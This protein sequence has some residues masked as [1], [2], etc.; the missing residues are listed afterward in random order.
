MTEQSLAI[1]IDLGTT[2][3]AI[4]VWHEG[5]AELIPNAVGKGLTPSVISIDEERNIM[6]GDAAKSRLI[7]RPDQ[8]A[9][10]FKRFLGTDKK[11]RLGQAEYSP[12]ELCSMVLK[13]LK[14]DAE[15]FLGSDVIDVVISVPAYFND[16]Q[17][18]QVTLAAE[19][20][21]LNAV[22]LINEPTAACL[23]YSLHETHDRQFLVFDLGGGTFDVT[24]V[25]HQEG[26]IEVRASAGD[27]FL[28]GDDF[29]A[30]LCS[31]VCNK[32]E[33]DAQSM[34]LKLLAK[35]MMA[36]EQAKQSEG[37]EIK[38]ALSEP[39]NQ[40]LTIDQ[41]Q[42]SQIWQE[43]LS[44]LGKPLRQALYDARISPKEIDELIFVGGATRL[45]LVQKMATRLIGR[46]G[47]SSLDPDLV[48]AMGAATQ[49]ACR[50]RD[51]A[52]EEI[53]LTDVAPFSL[54]VASN[55]EGQS[56]VFTPIIER[57]TVVPTS[58]VERF[59]TTYDDQDGV[60]IEV[61]QGERLWVKE[62]IFIDR[63]EVDVPKNSAGEEALDVRFSYDINGLLEVDVTIVSSGDITQKLIDRSPKEMNEEEKQRSRQRL[64]KL[65]YHPRD[66]IP[67]ITLMEKLGRLYEEKLSHERY[68]IEQLI[69]HLNSALESQDESKIREAV[70]KI[71]LEVAA[72]E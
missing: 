15:A 22:R 16:Q 54:G 21:G 23:A 69:F 48:V 70:K 33:L 3:S 42:A 39:I 61:Y 67:N 34:D 35:I 11:Y 49:A 29:T 55:R 38:I 37:A 51:E 52:V 63:M 25:E 43:L 24:I 53:V 8:T 50:L 14:S 19:L 46:F 62:N 72:Y 7:T 9:G 57:N 1:G 36:C 6:V 18:K 17:R 40:T 65:K 4:A 28:G 47:K 68:H 45:G 31:W 60:I 5:K 26:F 20:A 64:A 10:G 27:N 2:N 30:N 13:S 58:R 12:T 66:S 44:R 56:G 59:Y 41:D 32:L 71:N